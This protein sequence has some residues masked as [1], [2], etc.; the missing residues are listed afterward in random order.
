MMCARIDFDLIASVCINAG[1][2]WREEEGGGW[3]DA[4]LGR[5]GG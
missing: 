5:A 2:F 4:S 1:V 3:V